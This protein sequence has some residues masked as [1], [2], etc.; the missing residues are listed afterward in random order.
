MLLCTNPP[1]SLPRTHVE[2]ELAAA[3]LDLTVPAACMDGVLAQ[4]ALLARHAAILR[5]PDPP[6]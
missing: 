1:S 2:A 5:G 6:R 4:L 3:A